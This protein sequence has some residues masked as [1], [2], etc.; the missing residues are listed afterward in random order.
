LSEIVLSGVS[1][2]ESMPSELTLNQNFPNP[3]NPTTVIHFEIPQSGFV[4][5]K[6]FDILGREVAILVDGMKIAGSY[7]VPWDATSSGSGTYFC[8][9]ESNGY[10]K[11]RKMMVAK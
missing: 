5:L 4:R 3:F 11:T 1:P 6:V 9:L 7:S 2:I 10:S 8:R